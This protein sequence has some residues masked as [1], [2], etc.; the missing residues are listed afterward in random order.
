MVLQGDLTDSPVMFCPSFN[1]GQTSLL[2]YIPQYIQLTFPYPPRSWKDVPTTRL[3]SHGHGSLFGWLFSWSG[4]HQLRRV[5]RGERGNIHIL[6][7]DPPWR[8]PL[9]MTNSQD[10]TTEFARVLWNCGIPVVGVELH[11]LQS[12]YPILSSFTPLKINMFF[13]PFRHGGLV[14]DL[15]FLFNWIIFSFQPLISCGGSVLTHHALPLSRPMWCCF[16]CSWTWW[17]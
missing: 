14:S 1:S 5:V 11:F 17:S 8:M 3:R 13:H 4:G 9:L 6:V 12:K 16:W 15:L 10:W 2:C 7:K